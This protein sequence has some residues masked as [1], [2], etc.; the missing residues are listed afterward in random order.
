MASWNTNGLRRRRQ[1]EDFLRLSKE[2]D[3]IILQETL[4]HSSTR[5]VNF[6]GFLLYKKDAALPEKGRPVGGLAFLVSFS[7]LNSFQ[8]SIEPTEDCPVECLLLKFSRLPA[9][10]GNFPS[11]FYIF[12]VYLPPSSP[13][14]KFSEL[15][16]FLEEELVTKV[17]LDPV[18]VAG[19][20][21]CHATNRGLSFRT[22]RDF[23]LNEGFR[24]F[25]D[26]TSTVPTFVS[27]KGSSVI[28][29][30]FSRGLAL[31]DVACSV[32]PFESFGHRVI[33]CE[34]LFPELTSFPLAPR[35]SFRK[36]LRSIPN[37]SFFSDL[38]GREKW[39]DSVEML[40]RGV[41]VVFFVVCFNVSR[42]FVRSATPGLP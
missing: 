10:S 6:P 28:D 3:V 26:H 14:S 13:V 12:N 2:F 32:V 11:S 27:H 39:S 7:V 34:Y 23:L 15:R 9:A 33:V 8:V 38:R 35:S 41:S 5:Q 24:Q 1:S 16:S 22:F 21:N 19:D 31:S 40:K 25:P 4:V 29:F 17:Q 18:L 30:I 36:H 20:F 42:V 37:E